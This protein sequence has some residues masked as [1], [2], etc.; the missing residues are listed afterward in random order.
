[1]CAVIIISDVTVNGVRGSEE[2]CGSEP[3][4]G[5]EGGS[6]IVSDEA[7]PSSS[8]LRL[9]SEGFDGLF[10]VQAPPVSVTKSV[11]KKRGKG[12][13]P[14]GGERKGKGKAKMKGSCV[15]DGEEGGDVL[16][17]RRVCGGDPGREDGT[18]EL[19]EEWIPTREEVEEMEKE[20]AGEGWGEDEDTEYTTDEE[21][22]AGGCVSSQSY[23]FTFKLLFVFISDY[24]LGS[25]GFGG[26]RVKKPK[27]RPLSS[28]ES[29][30]DEEGEGGMWGR[31]RRRKR[32]QSQAANSQLDD[33]DEELFQLRI[34]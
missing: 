19:G 32:R 34:M 7:A 25:V 23:S 5:G 24:V 18:G 6:V 10:E 20:M 22:G 11:R 31:R 14:S 8:G 12:A 4:E 33:G 17:E 16:M 13:S 15:V 26:R 29:G 1:M 9:C 28:G 3:M 27:R 30:E 2:G 21:M